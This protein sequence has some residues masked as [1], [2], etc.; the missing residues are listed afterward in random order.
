MASLDT[1]FDRQTLSKVDSQYLEILENLPA[2]LYATDA[3]GIVTFFNRAAADL[4]GREPRIGKDRWCV[5]WRLYRPDGTLL[6]LDECPMARV[7]KE[8][9]PIRGEEV[10]AER[11]DGTRVP[12]MPF[13]TPIFD[14][15]GRLVGAVNMLVDNSERRNAVAQLETTETRYR[16]IFEGSRVALWDEDF[17][18]VL[19]LLDKLRAKGVTDVRAYFSE[20][21]RELA[22]A[23]KLVHVRDV[24][25]YTVE[26]FEAGDKTALLGALGAIFI[27]ATHAVF[28]EELVALWEGKR[29]F[30]S[31]SL[32]RTLKGRVLTVLL[33]ISWE[34]ERCE[35]SLV[36]ISDV[37]KQ[38]A[39]E[40]RLELLNRVATTLSSDLDLQRI[41][42]TVTETATALSGAKFGAFF[43][44][45]LDN[46]GERYLLYTLSGAPR[47]AFERF[48]LPRNTAVF[49]ATFRGSGI[50]RSDDIRK[51]PRYGHNPPHQGMPKG[52]LPVVSY[53]A[54][55]VV[56]RSGEVHGGLFFGHDQPGVFTEEAEK[57]V[58][59]IAAHAAVAIDNAN[60][61][62][63]A[64]REVDYQR[65]AEEAQRRLAMIVESSD[66]AIVS[67]NLHGIIASWNK[68][69]ER[70]FGY[71]AE[72]IVGRPVT[73]LIP[74]DH[75]DEE[76]RILER[77]RSG[78][79]V[80]HYDTVRRRK[81][82]SLVDV[83]LTVSPIK[84]G[85]G[86]IIGASKIAR[87]ISGRK[88]TER[89]LAKSVKEQATLYR[90]T[91]RLHRT[92]SSSDV[93]DAAFDAIADGLGCERAS[94]L[95]LD[96]SR[97]MRFVASRGISED[98]RRAVDGHSPWT[99]DVAYPA[100]LCI[101]DIEASD[102]PE[103]LKATIRSEGIAALA[104][105]PLIGASRLIGKF[106]TYY[107]EPH[108]FSEQ[109]L[110]L[111]LTIARQLSFGI[112][113][114]RAEEQR[115][116]YEESLR[117]S[118][119]RVE[120]ALTAGQMGAWEWNIDADKIIWSPGLE[121][122]HGLEPG[123]FGGTFEDFKRDIHP[124]DLGEVIAGI[125]QAIKTEGDYHIVYR[126][127]HPN[128]SLR[129]LEAFGRFVSEFDGTSK[130]LVGICTDITDRKASEAQ[131]DLLLAELSHRVKNT[132]ATVIS[133]ARQS[134]ARNQNVDD[135][136]A[137]FD[138]RIRALAQ[139]HTR[140]AEASWSGVSF[141]TML[142]DELAPYTRDDGSNMRFSGP[143]VR[144]SP[145]SALTLGMAIHELATNAA[146]HGA[147]SSKKG[148]V[149]ISW[150]LDPGRLLSI[151]WT[152][153]GGPPVG[154][155]ERSGFGR[156]L[157]ERALASDLHGDVRLDFARSG[158]TCSIS[159]PL[160]DRGASFVQ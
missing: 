143:P 7:I 32:V 15:A 53:L 17:S 8:Q 129:W 71:T 148:V 61:L 12:L 88:R 139:T 158:L 160:D 138:A 10:I 57:I 64:H 87:D 33:T 106:M 35:R 47:E 119:Q 110:D 30:E 121:R 153:S 145:R 70:I 59:G 73:T 102:L 95:L 114:T 80:D 155:P 150:R 49:D 142:N 154:P 77:I 100:P 58:A 1:V 120:M 74:E 152:E 96:R 21:P 45:V 117:Q 123:S 146:K 97:T 82:G 19:D 37:S 23:V 29:R 147:L 72:E 24:N 46:E 25:S 67:K 26:L 78:Q 115:R 31:E 107:P 125:Q 111:A 141:E 104:F 101:E 140:L 127:N 9:R 22:E 144:L 18:A 42:E 109:E 99:P 27:D 65:H 157:L 93:Y 60:L 52:H 36:S 34:G 90:F 55:P 39:T 118:E 151:T 51:D 122:I 91:D 75:Q 5:T 54:V 126:M 4:A 40:S 137:S 159:L 149:D 84:D 50:V 128:G 124:D 105:I 112:E 116:R 83:S 3:R 28:L 56:S 156:L 62:Q 136:I 66:D 48:G 44:N 86:R 92:Q 69:A 68:G 108:R 85:D 103:K 134:F 43:Y 6:P 76:P 41:V 98:Y 89:A 63:A 133:I 20:R 132:L 13:P 11:P 38:K 14:R 79:P 130:R 94:I 16:G 135:V 2:A 131:R 81:D 113:R